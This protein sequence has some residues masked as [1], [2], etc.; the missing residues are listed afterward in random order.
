MSANFK[1]K[2]SAAREEVCAVFIYLIYY[3]LPADVVMLVNLLGLMN[4]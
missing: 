4:V 1:E 2:V 3:A